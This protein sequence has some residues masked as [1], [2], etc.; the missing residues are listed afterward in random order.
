MGNGHCFWWDAYSKLPAFYSVVCWQARRTG[1][2][3]AIKMSSTEARWQGARAE[4]PRD[5]MLR[6]G[7]GMAT[8]VHLPFV[9]HLPFADI[10]PQSQPC[11]CQAQSE[12]R[13]QPLSVASR[14]AETD[15][16]PGQWH[17]SPLAAQRLQVRG[18][19][20]ERMRWDRIVNC[21]GTC[22]LSPPALWLSYKTR[23][24]TDSPSIWFCKN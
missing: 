4:V 1:E 20:T 24:F 16:Y 10:T 14:K 5:R 8:P 7:M 22:Y 15:S 13:G 21:S 23:L 9:L 3:C 11:S 18:L 2:D 12:G 17:N 6:L 19:D